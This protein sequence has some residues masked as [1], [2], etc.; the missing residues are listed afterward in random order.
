MASIIE[1]LQDQFGKP[2]L[3]SVILGSTGFSQHMS[4]EHLKFSKF[5]VIAA[6]KHRSCAQCQ[7]RTKYLNHLRW[8]E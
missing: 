2:V 1:M 8:T 6:L 4:H 5:H 7:M 3:T